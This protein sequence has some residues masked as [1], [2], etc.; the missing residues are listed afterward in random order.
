VAVRSLLR[1]AGDYAAY[2]QLLAQAPAEVMPS[3]QTVRN[4]LLGLLE[5]ISKAGSPQGIAPEELEKAR[6]ALVAWADEA[7]LRRD[8]PGRAEWQRET[9]QM[10]LFRTARAGNEFFDQLAQLR[11][12][13]SAAREIYFLALACGFQGQYAG[14]E[15]ERRAL[16][17][18]QFETL[19]AE[20]QARDVRGTAPLTPGAYQL[21][22]GRAS[23]SG[24]GLWVWLAGLLLFLALAYGA[25]WLL[26][27]TL[28]GEVPLPRG[29]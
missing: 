5:S 15:G 22:I 12:G 13:Q 1:F 4:Q 9:L 3:A 6:F 23:R 26:L 24:P 2:V 16:I 14:Q 27:R 17:E 25:G 7:L 21:E 19:R 18:Q 28:V 10:R 29:G 11:P 20:G 8:W